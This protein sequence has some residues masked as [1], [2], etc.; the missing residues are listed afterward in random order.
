MILKFKTDD[1]GWMTIDNI[2]SIHTRSPKNNE[3]DGDKPARLIARYQINNEIIE[4]NFSEEVY[5][6]NDEG[7]TIEILLR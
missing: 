6:C 4:M 5:L 3:M 7:K 1:D 2:D